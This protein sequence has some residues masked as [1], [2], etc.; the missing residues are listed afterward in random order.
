MTQYRYIARGRR[1]KWYPSLG[2]AQFHS[3]KIDAGLM[4]PTGRFVAYRVTVL[5]LW[6]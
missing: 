1:G 4:D 6:D 2:Q 3:K 5:K